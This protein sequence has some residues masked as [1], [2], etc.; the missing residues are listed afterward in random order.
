MVMKTLMRTILILVAIVGYLIAY[1]ATNSG[2][3]INAETL[4][5]EPKTIKV[6][7]EIQCGELTLLKV[8]ADE[9]KEIVD[10]PYPVY[11]PVYI[12]PKQQETIVDGPMFMEPI[13]SKGVTPLYIPD[14]A[15]N[16]PSDQ[17]FI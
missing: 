13:P 5:K 8:T 3:T 12:Y 9:H 6:F 2:S 10:R 11:H 14:L 1:N 16:V 7:G 15:Y 17:P 4:L